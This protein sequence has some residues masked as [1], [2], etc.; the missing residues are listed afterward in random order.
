MCLKTARSKRCCSVKTTQS[1]TTDFTA[2]DRKSTKLGNLEQN[3]TRSMFRTPD[4]AKPRLRHNPVC[5][6]LPVPVSGLLSAAPAARHS[7][8]P[9]CSA[10]AKLR[11]PCPGS[12]APPLFCSGTRAAQAVSNVRPFEAPLQQPQHSV[13]ASFLH[14]EASI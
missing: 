4:L 9:G 12:P 13:P 8:A 6:F 10:T 5:V 1:T 3:G 7:S 2:C 14:P 11:L